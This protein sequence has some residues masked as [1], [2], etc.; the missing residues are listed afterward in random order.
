MV[1]VNVNQDD[2]K[3]MNEFKTYYETVPQIFMLI[4]MDGCGPCNETKPEWFKLENVLKKYKTNKKIAIMSIER[5]F[6]EKLHLKGMKEPTSFPMMIYLHNQK[7]ENYEDASELPDNE[8]DRKIDSFV[9]WIETK[10]DNDGESQ[11][12]GSSTTN[13]G[14]LSQKG[15]IFIN[16]E[17]SGAFEHFLRNS[18]ISMLLSGAFGITFKAELQKGAT[19]TYRYL[20]QENFNQP[21]TCLLIK[22][23]CLFN[24]ENGEENEKLDF[25]SMGEEMRLNSVDIELFKRE[26]NIQTDIYLKTCDYLQP[27]CPAIVHA[28]SYTDK[29][30]DLNIETLLDI[31][32]STLQP[33][34]KQILSSI[35]ASYVGEEFSSLG[36]IAMEFANNYEELYYVLNHTREENTINYIYSI[37]YDRI[38]DLA[39]KT[40][41]THGDYHTS[42]IMV[43]TNYNIFYDG[44]L[45]EVLLIDFGFAQK[46]PERIM[47]Q[48]KQLYKNN[49]YLE[50][51]R[52]LCEIRRTDGMQMNTNTIYEWACHNYSEEDKAQ[53]NEFMQNELKPRRET[54]IHNLIQKFNYLHTREPSTYPTL[55][56]SSES[57]QNL[58]QGI[59]GGKKKLAKRKLKIPVRYLPNTLTKKDKKKQMKMLMKSRKLY[60]QKKYYKRPPVS[61]YKNKPSNHIVNARKIYNITNIKPGKELS[62]KTGCSVSA[63]NKIVQ[64]GEGAYYS[65]G[66]RPNQSPQS[67]GYA[68]LASSITGGKAA[69]VDYD[70]LK[71]GCDHKK[72]AF[73]LANKSKKK[74]N[75]GHSQTKKV[76]V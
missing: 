45:G 16:T 3:L 39:I 43:N 55:P 49:K 32:S 11:M 66:S 56:L 15:G 71:K 27:I 61:S 18:K 53:I 44:T 42:N 19:T 26:I 54:F 60:K 30:E 9:K 46:I 48:I 12:G 62:L 8:K 50:I 21:V 6:L 25:S 72:K 5:Q 67:W 1:F 65:S 36:I 7:A 64:K 17:D 73:I 2:D 69:A 75:Y 76:S 10:I 24:K 63:L 51:M 68:R 4:Y 20:S 40:G 70:I 22:V 33:K 58:F 29:D 57:K 41:Y 47:D 59:R 37:C 23:C 13:K 31:L 74:Y 14:T 52:E 35:R 38:I 28:G 34:E